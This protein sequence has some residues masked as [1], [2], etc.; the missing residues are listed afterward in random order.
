MPSFYFHL[1]DRR[2]IDDRVRSELP[3]ESAAR[4]RAIRLAR[5]IAA[6]SSLVR[7]RPWDVVVTDEAGI[8]LMSV[9]IPRAAP[10]R[11]A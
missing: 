1:E 5:Q 4:A 9:H 7:S 10:R 11:V 2:G 3:S 8:E 6:L